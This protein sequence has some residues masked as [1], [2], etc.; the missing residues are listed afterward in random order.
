MIEAITFD[1]WD[2]LVADGTDLAKR[3]AH[4]LPCP[5]RQ[6]RDLVYDTLIQHAATTSGAPLINETT[7]SLAYDTLDVAF[8]QNWLNHQLTWPLNEQVDIL[9]GALQCSLPSDVHACLC[10][11]LGAIELEVLPD[12]IEGQRDT[13]RALARS[14][15]LA[16]VS[17]TINT[18]GGLSASC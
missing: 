6:R 3:E 16:I 2:T 8:R 18:P 17:D 11:A 12:A 9:L 14:Y 1:L 5:Y 10:E 7:V 4:A 13:V 15:P